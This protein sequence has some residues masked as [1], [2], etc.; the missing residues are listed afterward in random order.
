MNE[1]GTDAEILDATLADYAVSG[2]TAIDRLRK[3]SATDIVRLMAYLCRL[4][5]DDFDKIE[6]K[7]QTM[8]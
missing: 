3:R 8:H 5:E 7:L 6:A 4:P 2:R 1:Q